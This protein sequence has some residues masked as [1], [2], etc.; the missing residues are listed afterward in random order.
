[1]RDRPGKVRLKT[2]LPFASAPVFAYFRALTKRQ[3][4]TLPDTLPASCRKKE[5]CNSD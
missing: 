3:P 5:T 2:P 4:D 1:M